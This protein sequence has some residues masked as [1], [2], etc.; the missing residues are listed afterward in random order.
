METPPPKPR[1]PPTCSV[2]KKTGTGHNARTCPERIRPELVQPGDCAICQKV[3]RA[4]DEMRLDC[5]EALIHYECM[6]RAFRKEDRC[7][8]CRITGPRKTERI[9]TSRPWVYPDSVL[10]SYLDCCECC[11]GYCGKKAPECERLYTGYADEDDEDYVCE[12]HFD[13]ACCGVLSTWE[14]ECPPDF[15]EPDIN[16]KERELG[17]DISRL[18]WVVYCKHLLKVSQTYMIFTQ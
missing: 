9:D 13:D 16:E 8:S 3:V 2:C 7:P 14:S 6:V 15:E 18:A 11:T 1:K 10:A 5:C 4:K 12:N 17:R